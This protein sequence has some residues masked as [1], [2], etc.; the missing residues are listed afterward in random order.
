MICSQIKVDS[1][2]HIYI[3]FELQL[4]DFHEKIPVFD[5]CDVAMTSHRFL[6]IYEIYFAH[7]FTVAYSRRGRG[8]EIILD[9]FWS[10]LRY[11]GN[12]RD[13]YVVGMV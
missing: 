4:K 2:K 13:T 1:V 12:Y 9:N 10:I 8:K 6:T 11:H 3:V 7:F 5:L